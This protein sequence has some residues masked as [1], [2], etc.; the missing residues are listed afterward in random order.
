MQK[1]SP[2]ILMADDDLDDVMMTEK[3]FKEAKLLNTFM[4]VHDGEELLQYLN[5]EDPFSDTSKYPKPGLILLDLNMP[6]LDGREA[7]QLIKEDP[8]LKLIPIVVL[9]TSKAEEDVYKTY[10]LGV[11]SYITKPITFEGL[12]NVIKPLCQYWFEIVEL[13]VV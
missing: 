1:K 2:L 6:K 10:D 8:K 4:A 13:P 3:A 5:N 7:L 11:N 12:V 9:T